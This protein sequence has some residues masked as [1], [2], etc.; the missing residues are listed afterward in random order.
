[1]ATWSINHPLVLDTDVLS[2]FLRT[3]YEGL[4]RRLY[5]KAIVLDVVEQE[6]NKVGPLRRALARVRDGAWLDFQVI[7]AISDVGL[8][9]MSLIKPTRKPSPLGRGESAVMAWVRLRG[10]T[11][12]SNNL[13]DVRSYCQRNSLPFMT[14]RAM[15]ADA[16]I[17][18][19]CLSLDDAEQFWKDMKATGRRLPCDTAVEAVDYYLHNPARIA[20]LWRD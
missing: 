16:V 7:D 13:R 8:E 3:G 18:R 9:Y 15:V 11:V 20:S 14:I 1:M 4:L 6:I 2:C 5:P 17:N 12:A 10:G 19:D